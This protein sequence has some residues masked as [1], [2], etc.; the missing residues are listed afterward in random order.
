MTILLA[1]FFVLNIVNPE[2]IDFAQTVYE[3]DQAFECTYKWK[4]IS[5]T[6]HRP[7]IDIFGYTAFRQVCDK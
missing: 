6:V 4:G 7:A 5:P 1:V 2:H 3:K